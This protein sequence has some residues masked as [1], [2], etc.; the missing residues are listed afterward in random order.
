MNR[1]TSLQIEAS[2]NTFAC[3]GTEKERVC[4]ILNC[5]QATLITGTIMISQLQEVLVSTPSTWEC[6]LERAMLRCVC[7][8]K[9]RCRYLGTE[10]G[11][12]STVT[13]LRGKAT[14]L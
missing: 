12:P 3:K 4:F 14:Q 8:P 10:K 13:D 1:E 9:S 11:G 2:T 5:L 7:L 6:N